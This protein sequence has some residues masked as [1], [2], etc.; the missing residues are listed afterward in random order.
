MRWIGNDA[1]SGEAGA[2]RWLA[3]P[4]AFYSVLFA[5]AIPMWIAL[6]G[7]LGLSFE[8]TATFVLP[9]IALLTWVSTRRRSSLPE[10]RERPTGYSNIAILLHWLTAIGCLA[11]IGL[12][13]YMVDLPMGSPER[14]YMYNLHASMGLTVGVLA[15]VQVWWRIRYKSPALPLDMWKLEVVATELIHWLLYACLLAMPMSGLA[16]MS[17]SKFGIKYFGLQI[18]PFFS[19]SRE[20]QDLFLGIHQGLSNALVLAVGL[21][22]AIAV[23]HL[24]VDRDSVF[25]SMLPRTTIRGN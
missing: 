11:L 16:A 3:N 14:S 6:R 10:A 13:W 18:G 22:V 20:L 9:V 19:A 24:L 2:L 21:H 15:A 12:G 1:H 25:Q 4:F 5:I 7:V 23:K 17:F 8:T